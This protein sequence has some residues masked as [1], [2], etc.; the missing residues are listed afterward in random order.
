LFVK[1]YIPRVQKCLKACTSCVICCLIGEYIMFL[2]KH[3]SRNKFD[4]PCTTIK[5]FYFSAKC[6]S[7]LEMIFCA[8]IAV[9]VVCT[10]H[11]LLKITLF[12]WNKSGRFACDMWDKSCSDFFWHLKCPWNRY[13]SASDV[14]DAVIKKT[15]PAESHALFTDWQ[16]VPCVTNM[17]QIPCLGLEGG[18]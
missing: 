3:K 11:T 6:P 12:L 10:Y 9:V 1:C 7:Q 17:S 13:N 5:K 2:M 8:W 4:I 18:G 14:C 16:V 15:H